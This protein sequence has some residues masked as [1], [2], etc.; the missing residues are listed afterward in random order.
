MSWLRSHAGFPRAI[1]LAMMFAFAAGLV[2]VHPVMIGEAVA[3]EA[4]QAQ[5]GH[6]DHHDDDGSSDGHDVSE[7]CAYCT[8]LAGKVFMPASFGL[9]VL[10]WTGRRFDA[11]AA[12][13]LQSLPPNSR[14]RPPISIA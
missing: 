11:V 6:G 4:M 7:T 8:V 14:F 13:P 10:M 1:A 9:P 2:H 12:S 5:H 3:S